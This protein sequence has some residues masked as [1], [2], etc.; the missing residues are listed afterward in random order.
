MQHNFL[1]WH[2]IFN[3]FSLLSGKTFLAK[4]IESIGKKNSTKKKKKATKIETIFDP[5]IMQIGAE[6]KT[7]IFL[8]KWISSEKKI[9]CS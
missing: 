8:R 2:F 6:K 7:W 3:F 1:E 5:Q 9:G 4:S